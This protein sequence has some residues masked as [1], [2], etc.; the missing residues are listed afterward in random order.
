MN[1]ADLCEV[2]AE[3]AGIPRTAAER[4]LNAVLDAATK[5]LADGGRI[6]L[7]GFGSFRVAD[8]RPRTGRN[9]QTGASIRIAACRSVRFIQSHELK[10]ALNPLASP[11]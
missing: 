10:D 8:R 4:A 6:T 3:A 2:M 5:H 1:R 9:P 7:A 11:R